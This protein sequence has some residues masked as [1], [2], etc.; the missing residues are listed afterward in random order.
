MSPQVGQMYQIQNSWS[1]GRTTSVVEQMNAQLKANGYM[2]INQALKVAYDK[3]KNSF[4]KKIMKS[5]KA[6]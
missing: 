1:S 3:S 6:L 2:A 4:C 5:G